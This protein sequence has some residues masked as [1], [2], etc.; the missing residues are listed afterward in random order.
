MTEVFD[1]IVIGAG[2]MGSAAA[3]Y[4]SERGQGVL[5][6]EQFELDHRQGSSYGYSR[7]IRYAYDH[8]EYVE[9]AKDTF[10]LW[11]AL[12]EKLGEQLVFQ[13]GG[14]D[15]GPAGEASLE[16]TIAAM[17]ASGLPYELLTLAESESRFPQFRLADNFK[18][19]YQPDSGFV[20]ASKA[21]LGHIKLA[22]AMG[23][24]VKDSAPVSALELQSDSVL[25]ATADGTYSAGKLI[26]TAGAWAKRLLKQTG[27]DLP[28][29]PLR[30]QLNFMAPP[31]STPF[32]AEKCPV[33]I[34]H[35]ASLFPEAIYG[36]PSHDGSGFKIAFH[37]GPAFAHPAE[38]DREPD[39]ENVAALRPFMRAHIP[40]I[41]EAPVRE[42][43]ICL[44]TQTPDEH[45]VV[46][47]HPEYAHVAIG[48]GF[49]GHG[50]KFSTT[51]GKMLTDIVLDGATPHNDSLFKIERFIA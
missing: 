2:A 32:E 20:K 6:L 18:A 4:L 15:F 46:D 49:S 28:L 31:E 9:L 25:V 30:C 8:P 35:V 42:S 24:V 22:K 36:I 44:Y 12:Q 38:I 10:P 7:I 51:I 33:W 26:V 1:A 13:T 3:Y 50:F 45:F 29:A 41:A 23:A 19:L 48:A 17:Q 37:G 14:L 47:R 11:F 16:A 27:L 43:R 21:V 34:A 39:A 40:G 5:L